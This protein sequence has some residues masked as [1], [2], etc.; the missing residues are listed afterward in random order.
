ML[1][2]TLLVSFSAFLLEGADAR[3]SDALQAASGG[4]EAIATGA[5]VRAVPLAAAQ[6]SA[7]P[8]PA[9]PDCDNP[10]IAASDPN[11]A[12]TVREVVVTG[13]RIAHV[14]TATPQPVQ[15]LTG[16]DIQDRG[17]TNVA[18]AINELSALGTGVTPIGGQDGFGTGFN[19]VDLFGLG[20]NRTLT[21]VNGL[22]FV[23]DNPNNIF[24]NTGGTQV[25]LNTLPT[26]FIDHVDTVYA[27][28]AAV[29]GSDAIS[30][31]INIIEKKKFEGVEFNLQGGESTYGDT[32]RYTVEVA[33]GR[34]F[35]NGKLNAAI[36][37]QYDRTNELSAADRPWSAE[38]NIFSPNP[39]YTGGP[40]SPPAS[41]STPNFRWS[42]MTEGGLPLL[43]DGQTPIY[44]PAGGGELTTTELQFGKGGALVPFNPGTVYGPFIGGNASGGDSFNLQPFTSLEVPLDRKIV[45]VMLNYDLAPNVRLH[46][47]FNYSDVGAIQQADQTIY[48]VA[49]FGLAPSFNSPFP[50]GATLM[51]LDNAFLSAQDKA[52]LQAN[53]VGAAGFYLSR[54]NTDVAPI[55]VT[56]TDRTFNAQLVAEGDFTA[57]DRKFVWNVGYTGGVA[58]TTFD[59]T[60]FIY[61]N[62][63]TLP[64]GQA[65]NVPDLYGYALDSVMVGGTPECRVTADNPGS[66]DPYISKCVPFNPF[67][68]GNNNAASLA[69]FTRPFNLAAE[70]IQQDIQANLSTTLLK[71]PAGDF[72][73]NIGYER[74]YEEASVA[75]N[76]NYEEGTGYS[77]PIGPQS[78]KYDTNEYYVE[79]F[80]PVFGAG[81]RFPLLYRLEL[82]GAWRDVQN[83]IAGENK[84]W[85][86]GAEYSPFRDLTIR[87]SRSKTFRNP[88]LQE[89]FSPATTA[90]DTGQDPCTTTNINTGPNPAV[91]AKNCAAAFAAL[92]VPLSSFT[93][94]LVETGTIP[95]TSGGNPDLKNEVGNSFTYGVVFQ[96]RFAPGL[97][98]TADYVEVNITNAIEYYGVGQSMETC[99]DDPVYP[100]PA[101]SLFQ[102]SPA[103]SSTP[104]MVTTAQE[105]FVNAGFERFAGANY[106]LYY[107]HAI[108]S[109]PLVHSTADLGL[110]SMNFNAVNIRHIVNSVSGLGFD[111]VNTA[112]TIGSPRW[113][114]ISTFTWSRGPVRVGW[115]SHWIQSSY[116][117]RN[118][119]A[120]PT[121]LG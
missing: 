112:G 119:C 46:G 5:G 51:S 42:G 3:A 55:P 82:Q 84:S 26:L 113:R 37:F 17:F 111:D 40:G 106:N 2:T 76:V 48:S 41:I 43:A 58:D 89:L 108:N 4:G 66:T 90:Y 103:N 45:T 62:S 75:P 78:G 44:Q 57:F 110:F 91:R 1:S 101:C 116:Y 50:G 47:N 64:N 95:V 28:G 73:S 120:A 9:R 18:D 102:R 109:L 33:A 8:L 32:P 69:Y 22:R 6:A 115:T 53:G 49:N 56:S 52:I 94:D 24:A 68:K 25:D 70:N 83:S 96:P 77:V 20:S 27:T 81:F 85:S 63:G 121:F 14:S 86:Y 30:G 10:A 107:S 97:V 59:T 87:G 92:G 23:G 21:L 71:L 11:C 65:Y 105:S 72:K 79:A 61:G 88:S 99:Y 29:Y 38:G 35:L 16:Q 104:G 31:V 74:R 67:G 39:A 80:M 7:R 54:A 93:T 13:T 100:N 114:W 12:S 34:D 15:V 60:Y 118:R 98:A 19:Y 36:D 117:N